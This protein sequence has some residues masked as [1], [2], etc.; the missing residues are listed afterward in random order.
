MSG[1]RSFSQ[2][3]RWSS[4]CRMELTFQVAIRRSGSVSYVDDLSSKFEGMTY[5]D[6]RGCDKRNANNGRKTG[7][8]PGGGD[9]PS[10]RA[11]T[12][13]LI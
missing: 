5:H 4:R 3:S 13:E 12:C 11:G 1:E 8:G 9:A 10:G 7:G 2:V 6:K